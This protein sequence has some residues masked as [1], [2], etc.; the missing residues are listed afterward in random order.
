MLK[1][2]NDS[3][4]RRYLMIMRVERCFGHKSTAFS[5]LEAVCTVLQRREGEAVNQ[6]SHACAVQ[7]ETSLTFVACT[8]TLTV[9]QING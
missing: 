7:A 5:V 8:L 9:P 2:P 4:P 1:P 6:G 3:D